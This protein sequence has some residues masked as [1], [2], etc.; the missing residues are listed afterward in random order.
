MEWLDKP[1][2]AEKDEIALR[3]KYFYKQ[4]YFYQTKALKSQSISD[5]LWMESTIDKIIKK[6][7]QQ[8]QQDKDTVYS[9][10]TYCLNINYR[11]K[12]RKNIT[13]NE[14]HSGNIDEDKIE[15]PLI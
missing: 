11:L 6:S 8:T 4:S 10:M 14:L 13:F 1:M 12:D 15:V 3:N 7:A 2:A 5:V 9:S